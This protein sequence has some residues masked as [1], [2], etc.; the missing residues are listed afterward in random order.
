MTNSHYHTGFNTIIA[1]SF[2]WG[3]CFFY[4]NTPPLY[5]DFDTAWHITAGDLIRQLG[6]LPTTDSW[7]FTAAGTAWYNISWLWDVLLSFAAQYFGIKSLYLINIFFYSAIIAAVAYNLVVRNLSLAVIA[8]TVFIVS[9]VMLRYA[10]LRPYSFGFLMLPFYQ[11]YLYRYTITKRVGYL[12]ILPILMIAW[13]NIHGGFIAGF[14]LIGAYGLAAIANRNW[15][16]VGHLLIIGFVCL[17]CALINPYGIDIYRGVTSTTASAFTARIDEWQR[18]IIS[19]DITTL[20]LLLFIAILNIREKSVYLADKFLAII[21][22]IGGFVYMRNMPVFVLCSVPLFAGN[23]AVSGI[24]RRFPDINT[25]SLRRYTNI[26]VVCLVAIMLLPPV[27]GM[28]LKKDVLNAENRL[29]TKA[30]DYIKLHYPGTRFL[31]DY[32]LGAYIIATSRGEMSVFVDGRAGTAYP[33]SVLQDY[34]YLTSTLPSLNDGVLERY[35]IGGV[36][37][38]RNKNLNK[39]FANKPDW[40]EVFVDNNYSI[41]VCN[42]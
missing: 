3:F 33:E 42:A 2:F 25:A 17:L 23:L 38:F 39:I 6:H 11:A 26:A 8:I 24:T 41:F 13:A 1:L 37:T 16:Q 35:K 21:W 4:L 36:I 12:I 31:N 30:L 29:P 19:S 22:L 9:F 7:S 14:I 32:G 20:Y 5:N 27:S 15:Q 10:C 34:L 40:K 18:F 28:I